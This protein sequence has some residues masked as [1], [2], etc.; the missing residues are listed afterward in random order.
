MH[1]AWYTI[2]GLKTCLR[3]IRS[4]DTFEIS[5]TVE[6][7]CDFR[8]TTQV[9]LIKTHMSV[10]NPYVTVKLYV[11]MQSWAQSSKEGLIGD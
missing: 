4:I 11:S 8:I 7:A 3:T 1:F 9:L 10:M 5:C 2:A 6:R